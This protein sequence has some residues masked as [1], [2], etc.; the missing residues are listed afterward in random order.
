VG[1]IKQPFEIWA[2]LARNARGVIGLWRY[3]VK[4]IELDGGGKKITPTMIAEM[5][6]R[7]HVGVRSISSWATDRSRDHGKGC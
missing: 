4:H 6:P 7:R 5:L 3:Y 1:T 2:S